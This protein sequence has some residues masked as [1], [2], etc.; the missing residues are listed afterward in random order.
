M[1]HPFY[2]YILYDQNLRESK[3]T[4]YTSPDVWMSKKFARR[5]RR[6]KE[7][8]KARVDMSLLPAW[9]Y[10]YVRTPTSDVSCPVANLKQEPPQKPCLRKQENRSISVMN[11]MVRVVACWFER[12]SWLNLLYEFPSPCLAFWPLP[13]QLKPE[14][15]ESWKR[16]SRTRSRSNRV[17]LRTPLRCQN[18]VRWS[19]KQYAL[20]KNLTMWP[21]LFLLSV[22]DF[23]QAKAMGELA[24][25]PVQKSCKI[26][27]FLA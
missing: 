8:R 14:M 23:Q 4:K 10:K 20:T 12:D 17:W 18:H 15:A 16:S 2:V 11:L 3:K 21:L 22:L 27:V 19:T 26:S 6:M 1:M 7:E 5:G 13:S 9:T 24:V 25:E